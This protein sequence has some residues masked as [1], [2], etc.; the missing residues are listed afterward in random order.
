MSRGDLTEAEWRILKD[1]LPIERKDRG[2]GRPPEQ[3][4]SIINGI[5]WRLRCGAPWRD[6]PPKYESWNTI[7][8]RFRR[9][10]E[11]GVWEIVAVTLAEIMA[12]TG[13]YSIDSTTVRAH[14]SAAGG[15]GGLIDALLA[16]RGAGSPV[17]FTAWLTPSAGRRLSPHRR[18]N[19][20][21]QGVRYP[22]RPARAYAR[23]VAG[24]Q[25]LRCRRHPR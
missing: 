16:A 2:R 4:R 5:L 7:Y 19:G 23:C 20:R 6:V 15:K 25:G 3:N 9:W 1:L 8:R 21:L 12:D 14:V 22:D 11:A 18:R 17:S 10:S 13:H 24:R